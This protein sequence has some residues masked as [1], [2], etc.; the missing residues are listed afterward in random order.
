MTSRPS[1]PLQFLVWGVLGIVLV[2][3]VVLFLRSQFHRSRLPQLGEVQPFS[4]TNQFCQ[5]VPLHDLAGKV[6]VADI[7]FTRCGGPCPKMTEEMSK[8]QSAFPPDEPLRFVTL[9]T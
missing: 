9:T 2:M 8:L 7:I 5:P 4:L 6:W 1:R 3:V